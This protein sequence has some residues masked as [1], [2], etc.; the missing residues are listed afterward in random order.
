MRQNPSPY[1]QH[2]GGRPLS[3]GIRVYNRRETRSI[4]MFSGNKQQIRLRTKLRDNAIDQPLAGKSNQRLVGAAHAGRLAAGE[5]C[6]D[7]GHRPQLARVAPMPAL[8]LLFFLTA[9]IY[10]SVGFGGGS[11]YNALLVLYGVDNQ[12]LPAIAL[13]CNIIVVAGGVWRFGAAGLIDVKRIAPW[14]AA[15]VPAAWIGGRLEIPQ[16][17]FVG[18]LAFSLAVAGV[19]LLFYRAPTQGRSRATRGLAFS[20]VGGGAIGLVSG[21]V[22]VGGGIFLAP[23]L[24]FMQWDGSRGIAGASALF[25]LANSLSG[26]AG[27]LTKISALG[28]QAEFAPFWPLFAS[29]LIGGLIGS[30]LGAMRLPETWM[31]RLTALLVLYVSARLLIRWLAM[32]QT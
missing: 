17:V 32:V 29:V 25:I 18:L 9:L 19:Q 22:G 31:R 16:S 20:V 1:R 12:I 5:N 27:Q 13:I 3:A 14:I 15:S 7:T 8:A 10:A 30:R 28:I 26:L 23:I 2:P 6:G 11:T 21:L 24:H 4:I